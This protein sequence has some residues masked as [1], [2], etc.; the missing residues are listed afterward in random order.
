MTWD[1]E[2]Y[3]KTMKYYWRE[4]DKPWLTSNLSFELQ[5]KVELFNT[6]VVEVTA[7]GEVELTVGGKWFNAGHGDVEYCNNTDDSGTYYDT[8]F[9]KFWVNQENS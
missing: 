4:K 2:V 6:E 8:G 3:G 7:Q 9:I 5:T 1:K